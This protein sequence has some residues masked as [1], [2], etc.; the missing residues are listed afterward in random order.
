MAP[1]VTR[2]GGCGGKGVSLLYYLT[3]IDHQ[4]TD[5]WHR[6]R[7][8]DAAQCTRSGTTPSDG[9]AKPAAP[10]RSETMADVHPQEVWPTGGLWQQG[11]GPKHTWAPRGLPATATATALVQVSPPPPT[12]TAAAA[13]GIG[14][15]IAAG[16]AAGNGFAPSDAVAAALGGQPAQP[17]SWAER[18][19]IRRCCVSKL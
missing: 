4:K 16:N 1:I 5:R 2:A 18:A 9:R 13:A 14:S 10:T 17:G 19:R 12:L 11:L 8:R 15:G 3:S 7:G 6:F